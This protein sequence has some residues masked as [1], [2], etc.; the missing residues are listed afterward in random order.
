M[1]SNHTPHYEGK[2]PDMS[3]QLRQL[4]SNR[5]QRVG[6]SRVSLD[7][8]LRETTWNADR[9]APDACDFFT[10]DPQEDPIPGYVETL[11]AYTAPESRDWFGYTFDLPAAREAAAASLAA[12][13][14]VPFDA[15]G[16][17]LTNGAFGALAACVKAVTDPG[18]EA[19]IILP[20]FHLYDPLCI[21]AGL[22]VARVWMNRETFD[23]DVDAI[24][25]AITER[26]R[27]VFINTPHNPT[28]KIYPPETLERL[29]RLLD[30]ASTRNGRRIYIISDE[31]LNRIVFDGIQ[32]HTPAEFYP[33]TLLCYS[34]GKTLLAPGERVGYIAMPP[35][36]PDRGSVAASVDTARTVSGYLHPNTVL[37]RALP[38]LEKLSIDV[39]NLQR[40]RD[41]LV[42]ALKEIGYHVLTPEGTFYLTPRSPWEDDWA[43]AGLLATH[44]IYTWPGQVVGLPG[45]FRI[46]LTATE[47]M[48]ERSI[49]GFEAAFKHARENP[50]EQA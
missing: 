11:Q 33:N 6:E 5:M 24:A 1:H 37:Q 2:G 32:F 28:G 22:S 14:G 41:R 9:K 42:G 12:H 50:P 17:M 49:P 15:A 36:M 40:K 34:Y 39:A 23:L 8:I 45:H 21:D 7:R 10:G 20:P 47:D 26:T 25:A 27:I 3:T 46:S 44:K 30:D 19:I 18:D 38:E 48:I 16:I 13:T 4:P 29:A 35:T 43:F 31:V